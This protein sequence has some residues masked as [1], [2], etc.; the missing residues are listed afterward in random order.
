MPVTMLTT[1]A[2]KPASAMIPQAQHGERGLFGG[3]QHHRAARGERGRDLLHRHHQRE[4]PGHDLRG[5]ADR[6]APD[7]GVEH[8]DGRGDGLEM[9]AGELGRPARGVAQLPDAAG[10][11]VA[12]RLRD[13]LAVVDR[14]Q[15]AELVLVGFDEVGEAVEQ[16]FAGQCGQPRPAAVVE[17]DAGRGDRAIDVGVRGVDHAGDLAAGGGVVDG[18][19]L[20]VARR[21]PGAVDEQRGFAAKKRLDA[22][23][24]SG[25]GGDSGGCVH[26]FCP[27]TGVRI[28]RITVLHMYV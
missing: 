16:A 23:R 15:L 25:L 27:Q 17:R 22:F 24:I 18:D 14:L 8:A 10:D 21:G 5:D 20:A 11:V 13:G 26:R 4:I 2:G 28:T 3:F 12:G 19:R 6:L 1:P 7:I 9:F